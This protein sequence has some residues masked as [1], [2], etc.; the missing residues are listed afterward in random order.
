MGTDVPPVGA[1][2][3]GRFGGVQPVISRQATSSARSPAAP[4]R[5]RPERPPR[6]TTRSPYV[7]VG[8][9]PG[10]LDTSQGLLVR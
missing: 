5:A 3:G 1:I 8:A 2:G 4:L 6:H 10:Q 9:L 7:S